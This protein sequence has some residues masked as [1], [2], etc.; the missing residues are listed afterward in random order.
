M[1]E[2]RVESGSDEEVQPA[3]VFE[4]TDSEDD[5]N[6]PGR[7]GPS[8]QITCPQCNLVHSGFC[9]VADPPLNLP[10]PRDGPILFPKSNTASRDPMQTAKP[11]FSPAPPPPHAGSA[12]AA[13]PPPAQ[14]GPSASGRAEGAN[15][16]SFETNYA[17]P[18]LDACLRRFE[19]D[20]RSSFTLNRIDPAKIERIVPKLV[21]LV[22][23]GNEIRDTT[24]LSAVTSKD[25]QHSMQYEIKC[26]GEGGI[27]FFA[28][29]VRLVAKIKISQIADLDIVQT[30]GG[31]M[32]KLITTSNWFCA[33]GHQNS[34]SREAC[35]TA[36]CQLSR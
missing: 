22:N 27:L 17:S 35:A 15:I 23:V 14:A 6:L 5:S 10:P 32:R 29:K 2:I 19:D 20:L 21:A 33:N 26:T 12:Y 8:L 1:A 36:G 16:T 3:R 24:I 7:G 9:A 34:A 13:P 4:D 30:Y 25:Y 11:E 18:T 31:Q 28:P